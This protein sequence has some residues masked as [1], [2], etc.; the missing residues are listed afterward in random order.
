MN[1]AWIDIGKSERFDGLFYIALS[2]V[3]KLNDLLI[4]PFTYER[5]IKA[6]EYRAAEEDR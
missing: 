3:R 4:E 5:L 1:K 6:F 2:R